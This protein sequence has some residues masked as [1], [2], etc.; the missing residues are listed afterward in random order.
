MPH[1]FSPQ[2]EG[3]GDGEKS[4]ML[5]HFGDVLEGL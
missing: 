3:D 5:L 4:G 2:G 1:L